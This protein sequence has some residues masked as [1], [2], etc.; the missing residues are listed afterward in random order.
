MGGWL[1]VVIF[2]LS[3]CRLRRS[4]RQ[5]GRRKF[6]VPILYCEENGD[7]CFYYLH[8]TGGVGQERGDRARVC[9]CVCVGAWDGVL[10]F[11]GEETL[12]LT[13]PGGVCTCVGCGCFCLGGG[14][15]RDYETR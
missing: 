12:D 6:V 1:L 15:E 5:H 4:R 8:S 3:R 2:V 7:V 13:Q 9:V 10:F 11:C 14:A